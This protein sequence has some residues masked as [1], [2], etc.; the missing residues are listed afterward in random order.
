V[1]KST[2]ICEVHKQPSVPLAA[3]EEHRRQHFAISEEDK[4]ILMKCSDGGAQSA[5]EAESYVYRDQRQYA[6]RHL[7]SGAQT[8]RSRII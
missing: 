1:Q 6:A 5:A 4:S 8:P 2:L 3:D 7:E